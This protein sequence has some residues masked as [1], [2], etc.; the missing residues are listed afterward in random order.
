MSKKGCIGT[1]FLLHHII[2]GVMGM[3]PS[4]TFSSGVHALALSIAN[5]LNDAEL[6]LFAAALTQLADTL[7]VIAVCRTNEQNHS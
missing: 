6:A 4:N 7:A 5:Q 2:K 3:N 1:L